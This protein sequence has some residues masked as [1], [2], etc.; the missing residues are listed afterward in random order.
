MRTAGM[1]II[2]AAAFM[3]VVVLMTGCGNGEPSATAPSQ[4]EEN[5]EVI[6]QTTCPVGNKP[7]DK[8]I[9]VEHEG[10]QVYFCHQTC[11]ETFQENPAKYMA[12]LNAPK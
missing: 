5:G 2:L 3:G 4:A 6:T 7:I 9:F 11:L 1:A 12:K 10:R 8:S